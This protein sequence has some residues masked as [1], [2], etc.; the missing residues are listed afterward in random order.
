MLTSRRR[1]WIVTI[2]SF[3]QWL[4]TIENHW[5]TIGCNGCWTNYH[6]KAIGANA[7]GNGLWSYRINSQRGNHW[8]FHRAQDFTTV[9]VYSPA[10][11]GHVGRAEVY[12]GKMTV[13][14]SC[15]NCKV[16]NCAELFHPFII[17]LSTC[18][19]FL[20]Q[21]GALYVTMRQKWIEMKPTFCFSLSPMQECYNSYP[22]LQ[23]Q[24]KK[25]TYLM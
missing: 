11:E 2:P 4:A 14:P 19:G 9:V 17:L 13:E 12:Q 24:C 8:P 16:L 23:Y 3:D 18:S 25:L 22:G 1:R 10:C 21:T 15:S 20:P 5:K 7:I 6:R